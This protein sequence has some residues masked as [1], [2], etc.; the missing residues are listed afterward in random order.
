MTAGTVECIHGLDPRGC[1][2]CIHGVSRPEPVT[3][4]YGPLEASLGGQCSECDLPVVAGQMIVYL[5]TGRWVHD[6]CQ[7]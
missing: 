2:I 4:V 5:S 6:G 7:P 1:T 3:V